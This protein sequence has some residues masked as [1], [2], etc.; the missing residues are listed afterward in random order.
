AGRLG[1]R[2]WPPS[3]RAAAPGTPAPSRRRSART[4]SSPAA[5]YGSSCG[6]CGRDAAG[7]TASR[8]DPS[9][10]SSSRSPRPRG[11]RRR[12]ARRGGRP[13]R[14]WRRPETAFGCR[15]LSSAPAV[16]PLL[17]DSCRV[18]GG[19]GEGVSNGAPASDRG[20]S[21]GAGLAG[22]EVDDVRRLGAVLDQVLV[23]VG[24]PPLPRLVPVALAGLLAAV[25]R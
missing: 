18:L 20:V 12:A 6:G 5:Y 9:A 19:L 16:E 23:G 13:T 3:D 11:R 4:G 10:A 17:A 14:P 24:D 25:V 8:P 7:S 2:R 22:R 1:R 21:A 15:M